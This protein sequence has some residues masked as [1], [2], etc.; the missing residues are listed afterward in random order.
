M[1]F[2][3]PGVSMERWAV[4]L[5]SNIEKIASFDLV[6]EERHLVFVGFGYCR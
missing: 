5:K 3:D 2:D 4:G 1:C 6:R